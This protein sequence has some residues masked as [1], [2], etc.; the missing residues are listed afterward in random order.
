L[1]TPGISAEKDYTSAKIRRNWRLRQQIQFGLSNKREKPPG[2]GSSGIPK[3]A[4]L[5]KTKADSSS[6]VP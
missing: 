1:F 6:S 4:A 2:V 5:A 3:P